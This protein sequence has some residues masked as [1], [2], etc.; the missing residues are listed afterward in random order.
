MNKKQLLLIVVAGVGAIAL[1]TFGVAQIIGRDNAVSAQEVADRAE[2]AQ[3]KLLDNAGPDSTVHMVKIRYQPEH[4]PPTG[5][6]MLPQRTKQELWVYFDAD[7]RLASV[8]SETRDEATGELVQSAEWANGTLRM[9]DTASGATRDIPVEGTVTALRENFL[10]LQVSI[11][12][13]VS[14]GDRA[15]QTAK[16]SEVDVYVLDQALGENGTIDRTY[17]DQTDY[18]TL[19][20][21]RLNGN[22]T[23]IE[24]LETPVLEIVAGKL[25]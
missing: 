5:P 21:E 13:A 17:I 24:S 15:A 6:F 14:D 4:A 7:G 22:G 12:D 2:L 11:V 19:K 9:T 25:R 8:V 23:I 3:S 20:W 16:V 10:N 18:R 1:A